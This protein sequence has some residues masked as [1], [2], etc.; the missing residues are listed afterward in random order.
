[1]LLEKN[2]LLDLGSKLCQ[3]SVYCWEGRCWLTVEGD[4]RDHILTAGDNHTVQL[5]GRVVITAL[6]K[7]RLQLI[8]NCEKTLIVPALTS[9]CN[10]G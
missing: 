6:T 3:V 1:M 5:C 4:D 10:N 9:C 7:T 8:R 2:E